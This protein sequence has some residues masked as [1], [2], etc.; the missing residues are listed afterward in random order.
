M[1]QQQPAVPRFGLI[2]A[3]EKEMLQV[4]RFFPSVRTDTSTGIGIA[5]IKGIDGKIREVYFD[6]SVTNQGNIESA[7]KATKLIIKHGVSHIILAGTAGGI[8]QD[9]DQTYD[10]IIST[11]INYYE[12]SSYGNG[13][14]GNR[15]YRINQ[16]DQ[17][18]INIARVLL[19]RNY[20]FLP[21]FRSAGLAI[22][23]ADGLN[24]KLGGILSGEKTLNVSRVEKLDKFIPSFAKRFSETDLKDYVALEQEAAGVALACTNMGDVGYLVVKG[25]SDKVVGGTSKERKERFESAAAKSVMV[26][27]RLI[28][29]MGTVAPENV[30]LLPVESDFFIRSLKLHGGAANQVIIT[31]EDLLSIL[32]GGSN[33]GRIFVIQGDA[34]IG[35]TTLVR[36][37]YNAANVLTDYTPFLKSLAELK[38]SD[39]V[40][41]YLNSNCG[42]SGNR[43]IMLDGLNEVSSLEV[44]EI[45][46]AV[47][48][49]MEGGAYNRSDELIIVITD[50]KSG[51]RF[52]S[53]ITRIELLPLDLEIASKQFSSHFGANAWKNF[54]AGNPKLAELMTNPFFLSRALQL[55]LWN[56]A[57]VA[58]SDHELLGEYF[59]LVLSKFDPARV[60]PDIGKFVWE[61]CYGSMD[62]YT[63][64]EGDFLEFMKEKGHDSGSILESLVS[65]KVV[66]SAG[67]NLKFRHQ[68]YPEFL[69][70]S[71][72]SK[73]KKLWTH[74]TFDRLTFYANSESGVKLLTGIILKAN[75]E[76]IEDF[77]T[78][79]Y[80]WNWHMAAVHMALIPP[81]DSIRKV[82][83]AV[84]TMVALKLGDGIYSA[85]VTARKIL[86]GGRARN[87]D[88]IT[89]LI[90]SGGS[91]DSILDLVRRTARYPAEGE[92]GQDWFSR[93][94]KVLGSMPPETDV[95]YLIG[96]MKEDNSLIGWTAA[97]IFRIL[98]QSNTGLNREEILNNLNQVLENCNDGS[99]HCNSVRW[100]V[101]HALGA[102]YDIEGAGEKLLKLYS[103]SRE[104]M[105][106][107]Y[108]AARAIMEQAASLF[109]QGEKDAINRGRK[110]LDDLLKDPIHYSD[111]PIRRE[112]CN[113]TL[114]LNIDPGRRGEWVEMIKEK[115][116]DRCKKE[117]KEDEDTDFNENLEKYTKGELK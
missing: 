83:A 45:L 28:R 35:K 106:V 57:A 69:A 19:S 11:G 66:E 32:F 89:G 20:N 8:S 96:L 22:N 95:Q 77:I 81:D 73:D 64:T 16:P 99:D 30:D 86:E 36:Y 54:V 100:R 110:L 60:I 34:G 78:G 51:R 98:Y 9:Q 87:D 117:L 12:R 21:E 74:D 63:F 52:P 48:N 59:D 13:N 108:G 92:G 104:N 75:K 29:S 39:K 3:V 113:A 107:R 112:I 93:W 4:R 88:F 67:D 84:L 42:G 76:S 18:M 44:D 10:V 50:R 105:W 68:Y 58:A 17:K 40:K 82:R 102:L 38:N 115:I 94:L 62:I 85:R 72:L 43:I 61:K 49:Y 116:L 26:A 111:P 15:E 109:Q 71:Y 6:F 91:R 31:Y 55:Y 79:V 37:L 24:I 80:D 53:R 103:N 25:I 47:S 46:S 33:G 101:V 56:P 97:N 1:V 27:H 5:R 2:V 41:E 90:N 7:V 14:L 114:N 65:A 23:E 70:S